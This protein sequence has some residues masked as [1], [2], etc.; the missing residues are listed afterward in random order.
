MI[1]SENTSIISDGF[2]PLISAFI[3]GYFSVWVYKQGIK[4]ELQKEKK[5]KIQENFQTEQYFFYNIESFLF[6]INLQIDEISITSKACKNWSNQNLIL[7]IKSELKLTELRELDFKNLYQIF[8]IDREGNTD[9]KAVDFINLK[10]CLHNIEDFTINHKRNNKTISADLVQEIDLW[11]VNVKLLN[12][13]YNNFVK[14]SPTEFDIL[15]KIC[16]KYLNII[17]NQIMIQGVSNNMKIMY[18]NVIEPL[19]LE[20]KEYNNTFDKRIYELI[21]ILISCKKT[22]ERVESLRKSRRRGLINSG[23]RLNKVK[24]LLKES[25]ENLKS[26]KKRYK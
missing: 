26:R 19:R 23:R 9:N 22:Y 24:L 21:E 14:N 17:Q 20:I 12:D 16:H 10:N 2:I 13:L 8:V 25:M 1:I 3:G 11:N 4:K 18:D 7:A 6:F 5:D 15:I